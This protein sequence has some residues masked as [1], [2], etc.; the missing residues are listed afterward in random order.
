MAGF[1]EKI[2]TQPSL[3][4][5]RGRPYGVVCVLSGIEL[6]KSYLKRKDVTSALYYAEMFGDNQLAGSGNV[7]ERIDGDKIA[8][9]S[10]SGFGIPLSEHVKF[11]GS[12]SR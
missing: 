4:G 8:G 5:W 9:S 7:F 12:C 11:G 6:A 2:L 1:N 10:I 3:K